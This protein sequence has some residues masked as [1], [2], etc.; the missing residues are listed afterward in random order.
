MKKYP[1]NVL[2]KWH[3]V[4]KAFDAK[5]QASL[6]LEKGTNQVCLKINGKSYSFL[7]AWRLYRFLI[8]RPSPWYLRMI[9]SSRF[10][11]FGTTLVKQEYTALFSKLKVSIYCV[12]A[13]HNLPS[14]W[15][16]L[17]ALIL[18]LIL[19]ILC[20]HSDVT[21]TALQRR[22]AF[23]QNQLLCKNLIRSSSKIRSETSLEE[24]KT[25]FCR[26]YYF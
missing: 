3:Y 15:A 25:T 13:K 1:L 4:R 7:H 12:N 19:A 21:H 10:L 26:D 9:A 2:H 24:V 20:L 16:L 17:K 6:S 22:I 5:Y 23:C 8:K 18:G 14:H 11:C